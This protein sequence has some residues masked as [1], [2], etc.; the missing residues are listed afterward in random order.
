MWAKVNLVKHDETPSAEAGA[1]VH[2]WPKPR[3]L[4][5]G[6]TETQG[7]RVVRL[8][9]GDGGPGDRPTGALGK[10]R[11]GRAQVRARGARGGGREARGAVGASLSEG[12]SESLH[13]RAPPP[14][15][16]HQPDSPDT[17][18]QLWGPRAPPS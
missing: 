8:R 2:T 13:T 16:P 10:V 7:A 11:P 6:G 17:S 1:Q 14:P 5:A 4:V 3:S 9:G 12:E 15:T 18:L